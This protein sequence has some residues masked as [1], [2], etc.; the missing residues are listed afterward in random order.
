MKEIPF[1]TLQRDSF[2]PLP[3][4]IPTPF[5]R[6][7]KTMHRYLAWPF[8]TSLNCNM[9]IWWGFFR[10]LAPTCTGM[11]AGAVCLKKPHHIVIL[12]FSEVVKGHANYHENHILSGFGYTGIKI[13]SKSQS[14]NNTI[15]IQQFFSQENA[16]LQILVYIFV[17]KTCQFNNAESNYKKEAF[18][19]KLYLILG[20]WNTILT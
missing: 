9:T 7:L 3:P 6:L 8:T 15:A 20:Q 18:L 11:S 14:S 13:G 10:L 17:A 4:E 5:H 1:L 12:W 16:K 19:E 2:D